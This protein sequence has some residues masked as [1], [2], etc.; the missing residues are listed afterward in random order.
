MPDKICPVIIPGR[1]MIPMP[2]MEF[3]VG[4]KAVSKE[5]LAKGSRIFLGV[6]PR[7]SRVFIRSL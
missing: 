5:L 6:A 7:F 1:D 2:T 4:S 3:S